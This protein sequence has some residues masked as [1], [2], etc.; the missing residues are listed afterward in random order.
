MKVS[1]ENNKLV[2]KI[3]LTQ[4]EGNPY[5]DDNDLRMVANLIGI[6][7]KDEYTISQLNDLSYKD[8][9]QEGSPI[10]YFNTKEE[11]EEACKI[12]GI[13]IWE[14]PICA[15]CGEAIRG[16]FTLGDK[17]NQ[18]FDCEAHLSKA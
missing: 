7:A 16:T 13:E 10:I 6:I 2:I 5:M 14:H 8:S 11:L 3:P 18:C 17:G 15:Y 12:C 1:K 9:Q 4:K